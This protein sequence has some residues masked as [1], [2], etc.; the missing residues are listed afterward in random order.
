M[1]E[2]VNLRQLHYFIAVAE[3]SGFRRAAQRLFITQPPLSRQIS[4]LEER[5]GAR[6]FERSGRQIQLTD[7][8]ERFL[9]QARELVR[10]ADTLA[11]QFGTPPAQ[12]Q[13]LRVGITSVV[14]ASLFSWVEADF[15][16]HFPDMRLHVT[17]QISV[18]SI[19]DLNAGA[20]DV[21]IIGLP[22]RTAGLTVEPLLHEP[23]LVG[24]AA[25]HPAAR[26]RK[27]ALRD[28]AHDTL[29]WFERKQN[30][31]YFAHCE[32]V[33][34][35]L[36]F[37]PAR[38]MEPQDYHTLLTLVAEGR[39]IAL[40]PRSLR[41]IQRSGM[42]YK[43]IAE[44]SQLGIGLALAWRAGERSERVAKFAAMVQARVAAGG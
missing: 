31:A 11:A 17:R 20:L 34:K 39:G 2:S 12:R 14:D 7:A 41:A 33:F 30:P 44:G 40:I 6:L 29:Y 4:A 24:M 13:A 23:M 21:A 28:F 18:Q 8:G 36:R 16:Q 26:R 25:T 22:S 10:H 19:R 15:A 3:E 9:A 32:Q 1:R 37:Q 38:L 42:V 5:L 35:R 43:D 27:L